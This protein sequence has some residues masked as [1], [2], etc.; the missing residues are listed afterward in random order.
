MT[1]DPYIHINY[2]EATNIPG[3]GGFYAWGTY[4][5]VS[6]LQATVSWEAQNVT[7]VGQIQAGSVSGTS[8]TA[9]SPCTWAFIFSNVAVH[10]A[11]VKVTVTGDSSGGPISNSVPSCMIGPVYFQAK[12]K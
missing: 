4:G 8:A 10:G 5:G 6:N 2:P 7:G 3:G 9:P 12:N 1:S 11:T